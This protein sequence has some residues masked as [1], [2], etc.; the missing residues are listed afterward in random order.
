MTDQ[1]S[2]PT[3]KRPDAL[4]NNPLDG[5]LTDLILG[6]DPDESL[7]RPSSKTPTVSSSIRL[8]V[9]VW[10]E[11]QEAAK[12]RG[13]GHLV[14]AQQLIEAGLA[15]LREGQTMVPLADVRL[16]LDQ[17]ARRTNPAA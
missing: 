5:D 13:I 2:T 14:L 7:P 17:L 4:P 6:A 16:L 1:P 3:D 9:D 10:E 15:Q 12:A 11:L 8:K